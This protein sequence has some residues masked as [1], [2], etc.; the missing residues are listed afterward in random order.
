M[1]AIVPRLRSGATDA[2]TGAVSNSARD[3]GSMNC[4]GALIDTSALLTPMIG[5]VTTGDSGLVRR[6]P[7][8]RSSPH[9]GIHSRA[10]RCARRVQQTISR[11]WN[12]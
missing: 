9:D 11:G 1:R 10:L 6:T 4:L 8:N 3:I 5:L 2:T 7:E 12:G